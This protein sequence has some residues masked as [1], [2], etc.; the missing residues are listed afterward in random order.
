METK[1]KTTITD[2]IING[3]KTAVTEI[4]EL[5]VQIALGKAETK[6]LYEN[7]K[8]KFSHSMHEAKIKLNVLQEK[9]SPEILEL[10]RLF[11]T[12]QVQLALGKAESKEAFEEQRKNII[13][14]LHTLEAAIRKNESANEYYS[15]FLEEIEKF[16]I[17]IDI[18]KLRFELKKMEAKTDFEIR[19]TEFLNKLSDLK[20]RMLAKEEKKNSRWEHFT[21]EINEAYQHLKNAFVG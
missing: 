2:K 7:V 13:K 21:E 14:S 3:L 16:K 1:E 18:L 17:K 11:E 19:K 15:Q 4:E 20:N 8:K 10:K 12:V 9:A 6:D 5:R